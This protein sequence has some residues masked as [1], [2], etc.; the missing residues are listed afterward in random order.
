[1]LG[2]HQTGESFLTTF[3]EFYLQGTT[4]E[5][6]L[7]RSRDLLLRIKCL[8]LLSK[9]PDESIPELYETMNQ[10]YEF[11]NIRV[12]DDKLLLPQSRA[13]EGSEVM[14]SAHDV[15]KY[16]LALTSEDEGDVISNLKLQKLLYYAQGFSL[17]IFDKSLFPETI[18]AWTHG[19]VVPEVYHEYKKYGDRGIPYQYDIDFS[20]FNEDTKELLDEVYEVYGQFAAWMLRNFTHD[21]PPW[22]DTPSGMEITHKSMK[23]HFVTQ[24]N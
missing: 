5:L 24:V 23:E 14:L 13:K 6:D 12:Q 17:A 20:K 8:L 1:M 7:E 9:I 3:R 15:A 18:E 22:R 2:I 21:E 11:Y 16:F 10:I 19:P 4:T